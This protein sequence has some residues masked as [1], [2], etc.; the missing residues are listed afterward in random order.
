MTPPARLLVIL[1]GAIGDVVCGMPLVQRL[2]VGWPAT[3]IAWAVESP[4]APL[5]QAHPAVDEVIVFRRGQG[6]G[7][8]VEF[9][10]AVRAASPDLTLD[11]QRHFKSGLTSWWSA[12]PRRVAFHWRNS[13]EGNC[14]FNTESIEP[15]REFTPKVAQFLC[16]AEHLGLAPVPLS[17]GLTARAPERE[18]VEGLLAGA[19]A[20]FAALYVGSTWPSR[21]WLPRPTAGLCRAL[22]A[23]GLGVV[24]LGAPAD[25][26]FALR[27][28][29]AGAGDVIDITGQTSL[30]ELIAVMERAAIAIGPD[31]GP[32][33]VAAAVGTPVVALFG[34][35]SPARSGPW[36]WHHLVVRGDAPCAPCYLSRCPIGQV[37]MEQITP[38]TVMERVRQVLSGVAVRQEWDEAK[39]SRAPVRG[40]ASDRVGR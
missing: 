40:C 35:T 34:A 25:G 38:A 6:A 28:L 27:I 1:L 31:S 10:R 21:R 12:A 4:A 32:M 22:R 7:A 13:R 29:A 15:V 37:C 3:R 9:L 26:P 2:R 20:R 8:L 30:R 18:R 17:F 14:F 36:G 5:L 33:H 19:G 16:F 23:Q 39:H 24:L 11:L